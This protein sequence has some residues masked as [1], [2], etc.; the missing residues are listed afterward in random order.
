MDKQKK[1]TR[2]FQMTPD[3]AIEF[4]ER[5]KAI[6]DKGV[7]DTP[8]LRQSILNYLMS[9]G[10]M[11]RVYDT[12][13]TPDEVVEGYQKQGLR[14]DD[15]RVKSVPSGNGQSNSRSIVGRLQRALERV[16]NF[17]TNRGAL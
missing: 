7:K 8:E 12:E 6:T 13:R 9:K 1:V 15:R 11:D 10:K 4:F 2:V 5:V 14:V 17:F 3:V 16:V